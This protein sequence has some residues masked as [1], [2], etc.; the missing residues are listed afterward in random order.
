MKNK[1]IMIR[2]LIV[3]LNRHPFIKQL[4]KLSKSVVRQLLLF[5]SVFKAYYITFVIN[6]L[7]KSNFFEIKL[8]LCINILTYLLRS[9][10]PDSR[11]GRYKP[12]ELCNYHHLNIVEN[13]MPFGNIDPYNQ[14]CTGKFYY[15]CKNHYR[16]ISN[17]TPGLDLKII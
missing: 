4:P 1:S 12:M 16:H 15:G 17:Y 10:C 5:R 2:V 14:L 11:Q 13:K 7:Y 3:A 9:V 8:L 6:Y